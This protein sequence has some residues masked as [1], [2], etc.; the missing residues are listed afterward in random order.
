M[1]PL[2]LSLIELLPVEL[3]LKAHV[4]ICDGPN[5]DRAATY[6]SCCQESFPAITEIS[7][8]FVVSEIIITGK[9]FLKALLVVE[10]L[11]L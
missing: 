6:F 2:K 7:S 4:A 3:P 10:L 11:L 5:T 8:S 1:L 9:L